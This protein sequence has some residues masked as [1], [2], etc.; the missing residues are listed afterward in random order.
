MYMQNENIKELAGQALRKAALNEEAKEYLLHNPVLFNLLL[1]AARRYIGGETL[2]ETLKTREALQNQGLMTS[3]EFM[4]ENVTNVAEANEAREEFLRIIESVRN[5][6]RQERVSLDLSHLGIFLNK[7]L[8]IDNFKKLAKVAQ[9]ANVDLFISAEGLDKTDEILEAYFQFSKEFPNVHITVQAYLHRSQKDIEQ[10]LKNS[11]G[12]I[13][14]VKGAYTGPKELF[15][16][17]GSE[18]NHRYMELLQM[19]LD[20]GRYCSIATHD[21]AMIQHIVSLLKLLQVSATQYEFEMLYGIES[22]LLDNLKKQGH[23]CRQYIV[24]GKEWYLYLCNRISEYPD[25]L[26]RALIDIMA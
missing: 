21:P 8:G 16:P 2:T 19:V 13:R 25:N 12:K 5:S 4:G 20:A 6:Q 23:P 14:L 22:E 7:A 11:R 3:L 1:K 15:L 26:F 24:Y 10:I 17:R 18:L 9:E